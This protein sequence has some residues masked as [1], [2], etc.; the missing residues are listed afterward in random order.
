M[1]VKI[2]IKRCVVGQEQKE[3]KEVNIQGVRRA[4][5]QN[6][7]ASARRNNVPDIRKS[8]LNRIT[9]KYLNWH[10]SRQT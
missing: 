8:S 5:Q 9:R 1:Q 7:K 6:S 4:L 10:P 3:L 2:A